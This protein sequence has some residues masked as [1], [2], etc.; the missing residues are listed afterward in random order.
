MP[1]ETPSPVETSS[2]VK[3]EN[4]TDAARKRGHRRQ[5]RQRLPPRRVPSLSKLACRFGGECGP[6]HKQASAWFT[7]ATLH[8]TLLVIM[9][10]LAE[11]VIK[12]LVPVNMDVHTINHDEPALENFAERF[13]GG[14][15]A[16][17]ARYAWRCNSRSRWR[18]FRLQSR[19]FSN[20]NS[21]LRRVANR[22]C[23]S[24]HTAAR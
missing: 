8:A 2:A 15:A 24:R 6:F 3:G 11:H 23:E 14:S 17:P 21:R 12:Q 16:F 20:R 9:C 1:S 5:P 22:G 4:D 7:S 19:R 18:N 10:L 13:P